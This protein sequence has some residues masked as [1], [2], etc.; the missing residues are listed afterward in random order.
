ML[1]MKFRLFVSRET[2]GLKYKNTITDIVSKQIIRCSFY[3][4]VLQAVL[5]GDRTF[6]EVGLV[7]DGVDEHRRTTQVWGEISSTI[8]FMMVSV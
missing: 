7:Q 3:R 1:V 5:Y 8:N 6:P 4:L 2:S